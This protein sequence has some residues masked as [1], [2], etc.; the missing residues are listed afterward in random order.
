MF[1]GVLLRFTESYTVITYNDNMCQ[2]VETAALQECVLLLLQISQAASQVAVK[3]HL[4]VKLYCRRLYL[5]TAEKTTKQTVL[6]EASHV[7]P[8]LSTL[9]TVCLSC[10]K[11]KSLPNC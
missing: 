7:V 4:A 1:R 6:C 11:S 10:W 2:R 3:Y 8:V 5:P 9:S